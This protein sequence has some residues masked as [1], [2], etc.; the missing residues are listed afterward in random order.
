M[1][2]NIPFR[3]LSILGQIGAICIFV[4]LAAAQFT[5]PAW[6]A[7]TDA[8]A[9]PSAIGPQWISTGSL[10]TSRYIHTATLLA[11]GRVLVTG[12][13]NFDAVLASAELFD[14]ASGR[15]IS[16]GAMNA[17]RHFHTAT[18][19]TDGRVLVAGGYPMT[20]NA[21]SSAELF[22][23][24][25]GQWSAAGA[26]AGSRAMHTATLLPDGRVLVVGGHNGNMFH[27]AGVTLASAELYDPASN[28]WSTTVAMTVSR[29]RHTVTMLADGR[30]LAVGGD[31]ELTSSEVYDPATGQ[32]SSAGILSIGHSGHN[33]IR[34][35]DGRV[36]VLGGG[37]DG[38]TSTELYDPVSDQWTLT[39]AL[40]TQVGDGSATLLPDGRV[41]VAG[42]GNAGGIFANVVLYDPVSGLWST[43]PGL[44]TARVDHTATL[45]ANGQVLVVAGF[46]ESN[47]ALS[48]AE[49]YDPS[50][51]RWST[52]GDMGMMHADYSATL[53]MDGQVLAAGGSSNYSAIGAS[54]RY[55]PDSGQWTTTGALNT[56][57]RLHTATLLADGRV[58]AA[59][60]W[61]PSSANPPSG[62]L[63]DPNNGRWYLTG[64]MQQARTNHSTVLLADG[65][66]LVAGGF[67]GNL[68]VVLASAELYDPA[69]GLWTSTGALNTARDM[70]TLTVLPNG[71]V[72]AAGG[73]NQ[74]FANGEFFHTFL[75]S[76]ELYDP[77]SGLWE[78][79]QPMTAPRLKPSATLL[80]DGRVLVVGGMN[81]VDFNG[82][83][84]ASDF[85]K[86]AEIYDPGTGNWSTT[87]ALAVGRGFHSATLLNSG[88][89][90]VA[91]GSNP[92][93]L[94]SA[95]LYDPGTGRWS[96]GGAL[97]IARESHIATL[98]QDGQVLLS[99][100]WQRIN[101]MD[102]ELTSAELYSRD[103]GDVEA[104]RP[105]IDT[106]HISSTNG[107]RLVLTGSGLRGDDY[108]QASGGAFNQSAS[109][110]PV[111]Q[112]QRLEQGPILRLQPDLAT[113]FTSTSYTSAAINSLPV[114]VYRVT[115]F[116]N[117]IPSRSKLISTNQA[118]TTVPDFYSTLEDNVLS[119]NAA[120]G[121]LANDRLPGVLTAQLLSGTAHGTLSLAAD[122]GLQYTPQANYNGSDSFQ[123]QASSGEETSPAITVT[124]TVSP[125][126]DQPVNTV[127]PLLPGSLRYGVD[128]TVTSGEWNDNLDLVPGVLSFS[129][130]WQSAATITGSW[131]NLT[132]AFTATYRPLAADVGRYLRVR[133]IAHDT[134][135]GQPTN[136][137]A[138]SNVVKVINTAPVI[139]QG[140][141]AIA[142][143][144]GLTLSATDAD[145][146]SLTWSITTAPL[147][148]SASLGVD[149][150]VTYTPSATCSRTDSFVVQVS[151]G[152]L[153]DKITVI[154]TAAGGECRLYVNDDATG[155]GTGMTW[156]DA[157][158]D[159][160]TALQRARSGDE[161]WVAGGTY[162]PTSDTNRTAS[163]VMKEGVRI[164]G[165]FAGSE[166][167]LEQRDWQAN[168]TSLS[169]DLGVKDSSLDNSYHVIRN[170]SNHLTAAAVLDGFTITAG[171]ANGTSSA[172]NGGGMYN[173]YSSPTI[174]N[175]TFTANQASYGGGMYNYYSSPSVLNVSFRNNNSTRAGGMSNTDSNPILM[176]VIFIG[177]S[178]TWGGGIENFRSSPALTN[179]AFI[180]NSA[181]G[182]GGGILVESFSNPTLTNVTFINNRTEGSGG[183]MDII[184]GS[185][186]LTNVS[187]L[188]NSAYQGGGVFNG[189]GTFFNNVIFSGNRATNGG[190]VFNFNTSSSFTNVTFSGN[191]A[192]Y[193]GGIYAYYFG[194][195][196]LHNS[197]LWGNTARFG[198]QTFANGT[199]IWIE[200]SI[201]QGHANDNADP[202]FVRPPSPGQDG[203]WGTDDDD[204]GDLRLQIASPAI[205]SGSNTLL[206][207][208]TA[209]LDGDSDRNEKI[210][211]DLDGN[212]RIVSSVVD[213]GAYESQQVNTPP[214]ISDILDQLAISGEPLSV[215]FTIDDD[216]TSLNHLTLSAS[217]SNP[218]LIPLNG[219]TFGGS[220]A[221]RTISLLPVAGQ[222]GTS[223]IT[224]TVSDS[225]GLLASDSFVL[226]VSLLPTPT[227]TPTPTPTDTPIPTPTDTPTPTPTDAVNPQKD[228]RNFLPAIVR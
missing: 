55:N 124:I 158:K 199:S 161:I 200:N 39:G 83:P 90:L 7:R 57:R 91:G 176:N 44:Q 168:L 223:N 49:L 141:A 190:G 188:G 51:N 195:P 214:T 116:V 82:G 11:D 144:P 205:N 89:V 154:Y 225:Q 148:G 139:T 133:V 137:T 22:D 27:T 127:A 113:P 74:G 193:G 118:P 109:N 34:L 92:N 77:V 50:V 138:Y 18:L 19:L 5:Q 76:V 70:F 132:G 217:S 125:V 78:E 185:P 171:N 80:A 29:L 93:R 72:L 155:M 52:T 69:S 48:S 178:A 117:G 64:A 37:R 156:T 3:R 35:H 175:I 60:G 169:G 67:D 73:F 4:L 213:M 106:V 189:S 173:D 194:S 140:D 13:K 162:K 129:Y 163:F 103:L 36:L 187:F 9:M 79:I 143:S 1:I 201:V 203:A 8:S 136:Q 42:G 198:S 186:I 150:A 56:A 157:M 204:Y 149:G 172:C 20:G 26:M 145:N 146:N 105:V 120:Q 165:G 28:T 43:G 151:D 94:D 197:I 111:V 167:I 99:G 206:P 224:I 122:G 227:D 218:V 66:V 96:E 21:L 71:R 184:E 130:Q 114:G 23:P 222:Q 209:D 17:A 6:A 128:A 110:L 108:N 100:G 107:T 59:G 16:T 97:S 152:L 164:Y 202:L 14:P 40:P 219:I 68:A 65:R 126:N 135:E 207:K 183:G 147:Y 159:L 102:V 210:P 166:T 123:Y 191:S 62:E 15:W 86:S 61:D 75:A 211:Y 177:N 179:V 31:W 38:V 115:V 33:A 12:G 63:Y 119:V 160:Q 104:W 121:V 81:N 215:P 95:E 221:N 170:Q 153:S 85:N 226:T 142:Y 24:V 2:F 134:G 208:D 88:Q 182:S 53:L 87:G 32:W 98:L 196:S 45:L 84:F 54:E 10:N 180:D 174:S 101:D 25:T 212:P 46:N 30:V 41:L 228:Y 131:I 220:G 58:L 192:E 181:S 216:E 112:L 47:R